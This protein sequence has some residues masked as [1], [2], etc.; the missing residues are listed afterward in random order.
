MQ[1]ST[2]CS[3]SSPS[4]L[5]KFSGST[6][7]YQ[8]SS[9]DEQGGCPV[10]VVV[11]CKV[12]ATANSPV[13]VLLVKNTSGPIV[14]MART[15]Q[16][17]K[18]SQQ[19]SPAKFAGKGGKAAK[20]LAMKTAG[21]GKHRR[22]CKDRCPVMPRGAP[23]DASTGRRRRYCAGTR[24]LL[25]IAFY[26]KRSGLLIAKLPFQ[27]VV[28]EITLDPVGKQDLRYQSSAILA[29]QEGAEGY[30][31]GLFEDTVLEAIHGK[32]VTVLPRDMQIARR[33]RGETEAT[34]SQPRIRRLDR[35][36][37]RGGRPRAGGH[38]GRGRGRGG[39]LKPRTY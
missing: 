8:A 18:K 38:R 33:I 30:L 6:P 24:S 17:S 28:R 31:V 15:K 36:R 3:P 12:V 9:D 37:G 5:S 32:R 4:S 26:Q 10:D 13:P 11:D 34:P 39:L 19:G 7:S 16:T 35:G 2:S 29:L 1:G 21:V 25:E 20:Q 27:R 14:E 23:A 22:R